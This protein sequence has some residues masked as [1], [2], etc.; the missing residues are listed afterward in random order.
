MWKK[1]FL[2]IAKKLMLTGIA[3]AVYLWI[4][5]KTGHGLPCVFYK[6]TGWQCPGCGMTRAVVEIYKG[7][8]EKAM[9]YNMLSLTVLPLVGIYVLYRLVREECCKKEG[10][11]IW[12]YV[13]LTG[14]LV[15]IL[16]YAYERNTI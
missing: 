4:V 7:N 5:L 10:F 8:Y 14:F 6:L 11:A 2:N 1:H 3:G 16:G 15:I 13:V 9:Q 12:E